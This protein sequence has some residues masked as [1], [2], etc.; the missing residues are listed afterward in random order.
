MKGRLWD[1]DHL[2]T[3]EAFYDIF[4]YLGTFKASFSSSS[5]E[6][7]NFRERLFAESLWAIS[8]KNSSTIDDTRLLILL[9]LFYSPGTGKKEQ[10]AIELAAICLDEIAKAQLVV[11]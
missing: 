8:Q 10:V 4:Y 5:Y 7:L 2:L 1:M 9:L 6:N 3:Y 11:M